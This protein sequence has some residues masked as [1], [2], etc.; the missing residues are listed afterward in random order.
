MQH[1]NVHPLLFS[2][3]VCVQINYLILPYVAS[4]DSSRLHK[5]HGQRIYYKHNNQHNLQLL[6]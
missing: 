6:Y 1:D 5:P 2:T 4:L 3:N